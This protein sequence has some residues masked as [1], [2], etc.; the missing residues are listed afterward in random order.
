MVGLGEA[1]ED[2]ISYY[3]DDRR[4]NKKDSKEGRAKVRVDAFRPSP[5]DL[6]RDMRPH[7]IVGTPQV[8]AKMTE[9]PAENTKSRAKVTTAPLNMSTLR[10]NRCIY[11]CLCVFVIPYCFPNL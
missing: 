11:V 3:N 2:V 7:I 10:Y 8:I 5:A 9:I 1:P 4:K 6:V